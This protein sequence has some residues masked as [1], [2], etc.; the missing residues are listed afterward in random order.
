[1]SKN[2]CNI[3]GANYEYVKGR[4]KCIACN[5]YKEDEL[6]P[7]ENTLICNAEQQLRLANFDDAEIAFD[8]II[9]K[10][11]NNP[12][13]YW[14]RLRAYYGIK[15]EVD[16]DGRQIPTCFVESIESILDHKDY[17]KAIELADNDT[18]ETYIE[19]AEYL[20]R[21]HKVWLEKAKNEEP[22]DI[23]ISYKDTENINGKSK[24]TQDSIDCQELY[25]HL[26]EQG[27]RVFYSRESLR[28]K[29]GEKYEPYIFNALSTAKVMIVYGS[30][31][32]YIN[33]TWLRNEWS[34][35]LKKIAKG[36]K[37]DNSLIVVCDGFSPNELP[38]ILSAKQCLDAT[39]REFYTDL[40]KSVKKI[41]DTDNKTKMVQNVSIENNHK[42]D[43]KKVK[44]VEA[45]CKQGGY[46]IY[47]CDCGK[48]KKTDFTPKRKTH[49]FGDWEIIR[50]STCEKDGIKKRVCL[51]CGNDEEEIIEPK[52]HSFSEWQ[53]S[54]DNSEE[55]RICS[56]CGF[57]E[58]KPKTFENKI[59]NKVNH[60]DKNHKH[61]FSKVR[62]V[63]PTCTEMGYTEWTCECGETKKS[64][65]T[66]KRNKHSYA[67]WEIIKEATCTEDGEKKRE[68]KICGHIEEVVIKTKGHKY[69][70]WQISLDDEH[71]KERVCSVCGFT[72]VQY[73]AE[74]Q[75]ELEKQQEEER[76]RIEK[77]QEERKKLE[78]ELLAYQKYKKEQRNTIKNSLFI[79]LPILA[80][81]ICLTTAIFIKPNLYWNITQAE[82]VN[83]FWTNVGKGGLTLLVFVGLVV[84]GIVIMYITEI[85]IENYW[86]FIPKGIVT[87]FL[88]YY[89]LTFKNSAVVYEYR[90][91]FLILGGICVI[92]SLIFD[93][94]SFFM[95]YIYEQGI[96]YSHVSQLFLIPIMLLA[97]HSM[98]FLSLTAFWIVF[99]GSIILAVVIWI[100]WL[101][102][103]NECWW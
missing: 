33:S 101:I 36:E 98:A 5:V 29:I 34:R 12:A 2:I 62:I 27:Y 84:L 83:D 67:N 95:T 99:I 86:Y 63:A 38:K 7:D 60:F 87:I 90:I 24:R 21:V 73:T 82:N 77:I 89:L 71:L 16:F 75:L 102:G 3:C 6:S 88:V 54:L 51:V 72:D 20:E 96:F 1:M 35:Y 28:D 93:F 68:C 47:T 25:I 92:C 94:S 19:Q 65:F 103:D 9:R 58:T 61:E 48:E 17:K 18:R 78:E 56:V 45:T 42:H 39:R 100:I 32:E 41:L 30:S 22:Y 13:G 8:D 40:D 49:E 59:E 4:W 97:T 26:K 80:F 64:D 53:D 52:G 14:G 11:P 55:E 57:I 44:V 46:T 85:D 81:I 23:F 10:Y 69:S 74:Y 79:G 91:P 70:N 66:P 50:E 76:K 43:Y 31:A 15:E 37:K